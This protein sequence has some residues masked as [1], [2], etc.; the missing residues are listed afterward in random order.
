MMK[1]KAKS[2]A[3][4]AFIKYWGKTD[5]ITRVPQNNSI[6]MCL[7]KMFSECEVEFRD[8]LKKDL[9]KFEGEKVVKDRE[10]E[11]IVKVLDRVRKIGNVNYR[12]TVNTKNNFPKATGIASSASG[13]SAVTLAGLGALRIKV[14]K[15]ELSKL[16]RLAS[17]TASR[18]IPDGFVEW[19]RGNDSET[20][21]AKTIFKPN[22]WKICDVVAVVSKK[23]K[24]VSS[25][26]GHA[27]ANTSPFYQLRLQG[28]E[29]KIKKIKQAMKKRDFSKFGRIV[30]DEALNMHAVCITSQ[31]PIIY[32]DPTTVEVM[33]RV[34]EW[35]NGGLESYFTIDAGPSVHVICL[36]KDCKII[37]QRL[38]KINGVKEAII[39]RPSIGARLLS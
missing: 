18:S 2:P 14:S 34:I 20:S 15:K 27:L 13:M 8:D 32:W 11:R 31:P 24:K 33:K 29:K 35:R 7:S 22:F 30:E 36:E 28:M 16:A 4:I 10:K 17:G 37:A 39:N 9:I 12:A 23:M 5:P 25:T 26:K 6:S 1:A 21:Y 3:N 38:R 19:E